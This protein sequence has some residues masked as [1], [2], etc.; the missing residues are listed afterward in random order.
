MTWT[1]A[2]LGPLELPREVRTVASNLR[3]EQDNTPTHA[4]T[5]MD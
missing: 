1:G 2:S 4:V 3:Q 5:E